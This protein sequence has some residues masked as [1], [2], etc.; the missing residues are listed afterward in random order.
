ML[1]SEEAFAIASRWGSLVQSSDPGA[2][3]YTFPVNDARVV[4]E[5]HREKLIAYTKECLAIA[6]AN[7]DPKPP[8]TPKDAE[9]L[10]ALLHYFET[11]PLSVVFEPG[12]L[13]EYCGDRATVVSNH[14]TY[15]WVQFEWGGRAKW[16]WNFQGTPV[17]LV[18][19]GKT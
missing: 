15:G 7:K 6:E 5:E 10:R 12:D 4:S 19:R 16:F 11:V 13:V 14:G 1:T 9:E 2:V 8:N 17:T 18:K 3:F